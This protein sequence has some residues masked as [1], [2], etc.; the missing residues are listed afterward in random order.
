MPDVAAACCA[1]F[2]GNP[3]SSASVASRSSYISSPDDKYGWAAAIC[4]GRY[5]AICEAPA[6][7]FPCH[8]PP[9][10]SPPP[11]LPPSPPSPPLPPSCAP[12]PN[13]TFFCTA[14]SCYS[15]QLQAASYSNARELCELLLPG[16]SLAQPRSGSQQLQVELY[17]QARG[18]LP[19]Y[20]T[21]ISRAD[22]SEVEHSSVSSLGPYSLADGAPVSDSVSVMDEEPYSHWAWVAG[23]AMGQPGQDCVLAH[24]QLAFDKYVGASAADATLAWNSGLFQANGALYADRK[25]GW[26]PAYCYEEH[27]VI[28]QVAPELLPCLPP[29]T[30]PMLPPSPPQS[31]APPAP[32]S[33]APAAS[34][35]FFC[36]P[37]TALCY[38]HTLLTPMAFDSARAE[39]RVR[40]AA[41]LGRSLQLFA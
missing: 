6:E 19:A 2:V 37:V 15:L 24:P 22:T 31:P 10:P 26:L 40:A 20:W 8:P 39:C 12:A 1:Q 16:S 21:G 4:N 25:Y 13:A 7:A 14:D 32:P 23:A 35:T 18:P 5:H 29:P 36:D 11:P 38:N 28:C 33:C 17:F 34:R 41:A 9:S 30:P 3:V 27:A